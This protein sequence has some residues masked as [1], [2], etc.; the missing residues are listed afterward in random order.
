METPFTQTQC[1]DLYLQD[2]TKVKLL[3][4]VHVPVHVLL[5]DST[6]LN[7]FNSSNAAK[8]F[9]KNFFTVFDIITTLL[10]IMI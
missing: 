3:M 9:K 6:V 10:T 4:S 2:F 8:I 1:L 7:L 5:W